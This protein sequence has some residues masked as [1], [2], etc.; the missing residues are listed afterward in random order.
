[1]TSWGPGKFD[2]QLFLDGK[3]FRPDGKTGGNADS[4][5]IRPGGRQPAHVDRMGSV[6]RTGTRLSPTSRCTAQ[7]TFYDPRLNDKVK[8][9]VAARAGFGNVPANGA[10]DGVTSRS[11]AAL[12]YYQLSIPAPAAPEGSFNA[13]LSGDGRGS[14]STGCASCASCHVPPL[15]TEP[16]WSMHTAERDRHRRLPVEPVAR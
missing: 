10:D 6:R 1:M 2:A 12:Q 3:G 13:A 9:P 16:G 7:G 15:F 4:A 11:C 8:Y 14:S 5:G